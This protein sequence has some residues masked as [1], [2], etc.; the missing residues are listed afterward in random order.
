LGERKR[1]TPGIHWGGGTT[2]AQKASASTRVGK[3]L[4]VPGRVVDRAATVLARRTDCSSGNPS[5][6]YT[7]NAPMKASPAPVV[8]DNLQIPQVLADFIVS[9]EKTK[10][11]LVRSQLQQEP[12][13]QADSQ[14][15]D[16]TGMQLAEPK[17]PML[18]WVS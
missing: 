9:S 14:F 5:A 6:R 15:P 13:A 2:V 12:K 10:D 11:G 1:F 4:W 3:E 8:C 18:G 7:A 17:P 16:A